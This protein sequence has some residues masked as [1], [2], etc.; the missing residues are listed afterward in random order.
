[1][2]K[3]F[4]LFPLILSTYFLNAQVINTFPYTQDF[5]SFN[6]CGTNC[7]ASCT[8]LASSG[9][10]NT[11]GDD[12][13]WIVD[14]GGTTSG[15]T[16]PSQ[17]HNPGTSA[18]KYIYVEAS[19]SGTGFP[20]KTALLISPYFDFSQQSSPILEF[21]NHMYG[22]TM[23]T[24]HIDVD[25]SKSATPVWVNDIV[26]AWTRN[27]N[28]WQFTSIS[29]AAFG[30][31]DSVRFRIRGITGSNFYS[32]MAVD[33]FTIFQ[34]IPNDGDMKEI[35]APISGCAAGINTPVSIRI[36]NFGTNTLNTIPVAYT[37]N[38]GALT[39]DTVFIPIAPLQDTVFTFTVGANLSVPGP[40][41]ITAFV[42]GLSGDSNNANDTTTANITIY[43]VASVTFPHLEDFE[44]GTNGWTSGGNNS[45]WQFGKPANTII[46]AASSGD[47]AWVTNLTGNHNANERS[48]VQS[49]C[50]DL[51]SL[52]F[53]HVEVDVWWNCQN[54][55]DGANLQTS[56][57]GGQTWQIVGAS[58]DPDNWYT[59]NTIN[60]SP[61]GNQH[62]WTGRNSQNNGSGGWRKAIHELNGLAGEP[63]VIFRMY[64]ASN[65]GTHDE[66]FGFDNFRLY[67]PGP[68]DVGV[69]GLA[70]PG[71]GNALRPACF[72]LDTIRVSVKNYGSDTLDFANS[73][74]R[75]ISVATGPS[76]SIDSVTITSG[77][78]LP[79]ASL[80]VTTNV[81]F[82]MSLP[83]TYTFTGYTKYLTGGPDSNP[84]NDT[85]NPISI[86]NGAVSVLP[87][88][89]FFEDFESFT[90]GSP[91]TVRN[92]WYRTT[93]GGFRWQVDNATTSSGST[94]PN[95][96]H[97]LGTNAGKYMYTEASST[98]GPAYLY[99]PCIDLTGVLGPIL[100]FWYHRYGAT[101]GNLVTQIYSNGAWVPIDSLSGQQHGG[102]GAAWTKRT[103]SLSAYAGQVIRLR[104]CGERGT[105]FT[106]DMAV[107]DIN[108]Y[109]PQPYDLEMISIVSP[110]SPGCSYTAAEPITI[111][112][113][114]VG[115]FPVNYDDVEATFT[116]TGPPNTGPLKDTLSGTGMIMPGDTI[117]YTLS[118]TANMATSTNY[119]ITSSIDFTAI[120]GFS[121]GAPINNFDTTT[122]IPGL[123]GTFTIDAG[124]PPSST[125]FQ[126]FAAAHTEMRTFGIC[127]P[128][129]F[130]V[131]AGSGPYQEQVLFD[132]IPGAS[133]TNTI[134][135]DGG[136][137]METVYVNTT[138]NGQRAVFKL[139]NGAS[140][141][142]LKRLTILNYGTNWGVGVHIRAASDYN[143]IDSCLIMVDTTF[144]R[145]STNFVGIQMA[146]NAAT[147]T[148]NS[149]DH[150][151]I[152]NNTIRSGYYGVSMTNVSTTDFATNNRI[153]NNVF[154]NQYAYGIRSYY[155]HAPEIRN[156]H[157]SL[158]H[159]QGT[160]GYGI[161]LGYSDSFRVEANYIQ[162][163][164]TYGIYMFNANNATRST[165]RANVINNMIYGV[166][167]S[168]TPYGMFL[169]SNTANINFY[170]NSIAVTSGNGRG[171][172]TTTTGVSG[173]DVRNNSFAT[174]NVGN[175]GRAVYVLDS[176]SFSF[177]D[178]NNFYN[179]GRNE[180]IFLDGRQ[181]TQ[182]D[183]NGAGGYNVLSSQG[184]PL[185]LD[186]F[187]D[188]HLKSS[189]LWDSGNNAVGVATDIDGDSRPGFG[190]LIVDIGADEF[191]PPA[192]EAELALI[193]TPNSG[194]SMSG[195]ELVTVQI[196]NNGRDT[197]KQVNV[198]YSL[199]GATPITETAI[200]SIPSRG[201]AN[202]TFTTTANLATLGSY[203]FDIWLSVVGDTCFVND[204]IFGHIVDNAPV[205]NMFPH[206]ESFENGPAGWVAGGTNST[207]QLGQPV[208]AVI[209]T[210]YH[211]I[212]AWMTD[213][214]GFYQ[215][216]SCSYV[217]SPCY[218]LST[219]GLPE[220][221][222][223]IWYDSWS[224]AD[225]TVLQATVDSGRTW[226][227]IGTMNAVGSSNWYNATAGGGGPITCLNQADRWTGRA[228]TNNGS[229]GWLLATAEA[230]NLAGEPEVRFRVFFSSNGTS[231]ANS[232]G[233]AFD[234]FSV[235]DLPPKNVG[236]VSLIEP[237]DGAC[238]DSSTVIAVTIENFGSQAQHNIPV[239]VTVDT[240]GTT[241]ASVNAIYTDTLQVK[242]LDTLIV[243]TFNSAAG[244]SFNFTLY[245]NHLGDLDNTNDTA[246]TTGVIIH[247]IPAPPTVVNDTLCAPDSTVL[248]ILP[249]SGFTYMWYDSA[250]GGNMIAGDTTHFQTP[251]LT[252]TTTYYV[253]A[254]DGSGG[255]GCL[256]IT[257]LNLTGT[258]VL[259]IQNMTN[260]T[261]DA[262]GWVAAISD[263]YTNINTVNSDLWNL[264]SFAGGAVEYRSDA[265]GPNYWGSNMFWNQSGSPGWAMIIDDQGNVVDAIFFQWSAAN[266]ANFN[267]TINGFTITAA[268]IPWFGAGTSTSSNPGVLSR[269]GATD[270]D[271][272]TD[273]SLT[274]AASTGQTNA[275]LSLPFT[276]CGGGSGCF[277]PRTPIT[278]IISAPVPV[279][280][281]PDRVTCGSA[282]L[283]AGAGFLGYR[284]NTGDTTQMINASATGGY[285]VVV[286]NTDGCVGHDTVIVNI[287][288]SPTVDLGPDTTICGSILLDA[289]NVGST[290]AWQDGSNS[291][292]YLAT[293]SSR[294]T[295][296]VTNSFQCSSTDTVDLVINP[297]PVVD[298]GFNRTECDE[299]TLSANNPG[300]G[301]LWST[302]DTVQ[303]I[304]VT[305]SGNYSVTV[306]DPSTGCFT[307]D[308][309]NLTIAGSPTVDLGADTTICDGDPLVLDAGNP[310]GT[311]LWSTGSTGQTETV[312][313]SGTISVMVTDING[314]EG[315]DTII[316]DTEPIAVAAFSVR[317]MVGSL[318]FDFTNLSIGGANQTFS[319][320]F[321]DGSSDTSKDPSHTYAFDGNY[322]VCLTIT[323]ACGDSTICDT[324]TVSL[325]NSLDG[326]QL[327]SHIQLFPN[328][329][330]GKVFVAFDG[331]NEEVKISITDIRGRMVLKRMVSRFEQ[332][333]ATELD[334]REEAEGVYLIHFE[335]GD[336]KLTQKLVL[337][338]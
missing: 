295:V 196:K 69:N 10:S 287:S 147:S 81:S 266:I 253:Q 11:S 304:T 189:P 331:L 43:P 183:Y 117:T 46:N 14:V 313:T 12:L 171:M 311:Y 277:S 257:E 33:D 256:R 131:V 229:G 186:P 73:N 243:G 329:S 250:V 92:G 149:A 83:G 51:S 66:G 85:L 39:I 327:A 286:T 93:T 50:F 15:S 48:W 215:H 26:P 211:G 224:T 77:T 307:I 115:I 76:N 38:G 91:G 232:D 240:N 260:G 276:G 18:G 187:T 328:P 188:L 220:I 61:G 53:P 139:R 306:T 305:T 262:T 274:Q 52:S 157:I 181:V 45:S 8:L 78:L 268:D 5:E 225:G 271:D 144:N 35:V 90:T 248:Y 185:Y 239:V 166:Y 27:Q 280:L 264:G 64:F 190:G 218:D 273:W 325:V 138:T 284:W 104:F 72:G 299:A 22:Q 175:N 275:N 278:A 55:T 254:M 326:N 298:L 332:Q 140:H 102:S 153:I 160:I 214:T 36:G 30:N 213:T 191:D 178:Y 128:V 132:A 161:Y 269:T 198:S 25:T 210:A 106:G 99:S 68:N 37:V 95:R 58:G 281:G 169:S 228:A 333:S 251:Y 141:Y 156:N 20:T 6:T 226:T 165:G 291:Q 98:G 288:P 89:P 60:A 114:N 173:L 112:F 146:G 217:L 71:N 270:N 84:P 125:N 75:V 310:G 199:N 330:D 28:S 279:D 164:K 179:S 105:S 41:T 142:V 222:M 87:G 62:G 23:G 317:Q 321:G 1:M 272:A 2:Q 282:M 152:T 40:Y 259:E 129:V 309:V 82:N 4:T 154:D 80:L 86:T 290:F 336:Q 200:V 238:G 223:G 192:K 308:S 241:I 334:L 315:T 134:T 123:S 318:T 258:D 122:V 296:T 261:I 97:T 236:A 49:P 148:I 249:D 70:A 109:E 193:L 208:G 212:K 136:P 127:G 100:E 227:T 335:V 24:M 201:T 96:D 320:T 63:S 235:R 204:S 44:S 177:F 108:I 194:C 294:Y 17:D 119:T 88:S 162:D 170:N 107:D 31:K 285:D 79:G 135:F 74:I 21:W 65:G 302:S 176:T 297:V 19:C 101:I 121:D 255:P 103:L 221:R 111:Q 197:L 245:T 57:D 180:L 118:P 120:S 316:V 337:K 323:D 300:F 292:T 263:S 202:Y 42:N 167:K 205:V 174:F 116:V 324:I 203:Q 319:W 247:P 47:S 207:W 303:D 34:P 216:N 113:T 124:S 242:Q 314:C 150:T 338:H 289:G 234:A 137:T 159:A 267:A 219:L 32:D 168:G 16:G 94:G 184:D 151:L 59:D 3:L 145:T 206:T 158:R 54:S 293:S 233:F 29:L 155:Q 13:D 301:V 244:G 237:M 110:V 322:I 126:T 283:D 130:N 195:T 182:A 252:A 163:P 246:F 9:W 143:T 56:V 7:G 172:Y 312:T 231:N 67:Q 209:D 133:A 265:T 230:P